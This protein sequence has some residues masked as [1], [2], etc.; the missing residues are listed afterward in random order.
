M[1]SR[2]LRDLRLY[3]FESGF[4][5]SAGWRLRIFSTLKTRRSRRFRHQASSPRK[6]W[7]S[8]S[9]SPRC[10]G[11]TVLRLL[12]SEPFGQILRIDRILAEEPGDDPSFFQ[13]EVYSLTETAALILFSY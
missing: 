10:S 9:I 13:D 8:Y 11:F 7:P 4:P 6:G 3:A 12:T 2:R 5:A 1:P